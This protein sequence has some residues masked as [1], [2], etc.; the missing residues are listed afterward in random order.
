MGI[1]TKINLLSSIGLISSSIGIGTLNGTEETFYSKISALHKKREISTSKVEDTLKDT[2]RSLR[3]KVKK[4]EKTLQKDPDE[5]NLEGT[6]NID[7]ITY[8]ISSKMNGG[9]ITTTIASSFQGQRLKVMSESETLNNFIIYS[10]MDVLSRAELEPNMTNISELTLDM[11]K[12]N[13]KKTAIENLGK[14]YKS[15]VLSKSNKRLLQLS[16]NKKIPTKLKEK[17]ESEGNAIEQKIAAMWLLIIF[18]TS[19][20]ISEE[21]KEQLQT[22]INGQV[23]QLIEEVESEDNAPEQKTAAMWLLGILYTSPVISGDSKEKIARCYLKT[24][25]DIAILYA[26]I[27]FN[28]NNDQENTLRTLIEKSI[29]NNS[30]PEKDV[31]EILSYKDGKIATDGSKQPPDYKLNPIKLSE[32]DYDEYSLDEKAKYYKEKGDHHM[33]SMLIL[34]PKFFNPHNENAIDINE[35]IDKAKKTPNASNKNIIIDIIKAFNG[36]PIAD[37]NVINNDK[38]ITDR[39]RD[40]IKRSLEKIQK[41]IQNKL[42]LQTYNEFKEQLALLKSQVSKIVKRYNRA[43]DMVLIANACEVKTLTEILLKDFVDNNELLLSFTQSLGAI[44]GG[45]QMWSDLKEKIEQI[46]GELDTVEK[47]ENSTSEVEEQKE[48]RSNRSGHQSGHRS[49]HRRD[50]RSG[51]RR[52]HRSGQN[53]QKE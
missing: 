24:C 44:Q 9:K 16:I 19:P 39:I 45:Q 47:G 37:L 36:E 14:F 21:S 34:L 31:F 35:A 17:V 7:G 48:K 2:V 5:K 51:H 29:I 18:Y 27:R 52:D 6:I 28:M 15:K 4:I 11:K 1:F 23:Q 3:E 8:E 25:R 32:Q 49:G 38:E 46:S 26:I 12:L 30:I 41:E 10:T 13:M 43:H 53:L 42:D 33:A 40:E 22:F 50:H 20:A